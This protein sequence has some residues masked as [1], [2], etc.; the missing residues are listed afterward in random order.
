MFSNWFGKKKKEATVDPQMLHD[1]NWSFLQ[2]DMHSHFIPGIDDGAQT[3]EDSIGLILKMKE[4]GYNQLITTPHINFDYYRNNNQIIL[5]GLQQVRQALE[6]RNIDMPVAAA[7]EYFIDDHFL[8][9][10]DNIASE[11]LLSVFDNKVLV[12][13]SFAMEPV[14]VFDIIFRMQ[15]LGYQPILAHPER[16]GYLQKRLEFFEQLRSKGVLLQLNAL[17]LSGYYGPTVKEMAE[18]LLNKQLY[19]YCGSDMHHLKHAAAM[20]RFTQSSTF[21]TL[22]SYPFL[23]RKVAPI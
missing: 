5:N 3:I 6:E 21:T 9:L 17:S 16:Y 11:P 7:A 4:L 20:Q 1:C 19:D 15:S 2:T 13:F 23:N 14:G 12:E 10:L 8:S 18:A 22:H